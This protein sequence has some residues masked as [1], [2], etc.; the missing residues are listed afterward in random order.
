M[1]EPV[2]HH[3]QIDAGDEMVSVAYF[4]ESDI[5]MPEWRRKTDITITGVEPEGILTTAKIEREIRKELNIS[6]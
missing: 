1:N 5:L 6:A 2:I 4:I 3:I